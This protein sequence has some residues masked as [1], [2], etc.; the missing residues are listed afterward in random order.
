[1]IIRYNE[2]ALSMYF[3][4]MKSNL[5]FLNLFQLNSGC[6]TFTNTNTQI[7][8]HIM[9]HI[10]TSSSLSQL[11]S[12]SLNSILIIIFLTNYMYKRQR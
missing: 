4:K 1:M 5:I 8:K 7:Q 2:L 6:N 10:F 11:V 3:V 12:S 9:Y